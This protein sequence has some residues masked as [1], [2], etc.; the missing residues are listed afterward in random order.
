V[1]VPAVSE[2][3]ILSWDLFGTATRDLAVEVFEDG[4]RPDLVLGI[5]R[6]GLFLAGGLGYALDVKN[7]HVINVEFY[8]G[9]DERLDMPVL[10]PPVP[11]PVDLTGAHVL[12]ADDVA[13]TGA[14]LALVKDYCERHVAEVRC[15]VVYEKSRSEVQ[16]EYVWRRTDRWID[17][18]WSAAGPVTGA[19]NRDA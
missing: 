12:I 3:E 1:A 8:T 18:P 4:F 16:C 14:T 2:R 11:E 17:F 15:A 9:V 6:G 5:A 10:L 7:L 19:A 13:D